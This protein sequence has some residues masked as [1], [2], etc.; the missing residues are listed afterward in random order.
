MF[1]PSFMTTSSQDINWIDRVENLFLRFGIK[2]IT[3]D[4]VAADLGISKKTLYQMVE[5]KDDLVIKVLE[6]HI[7]REKSKCLNLASKAPNA[8]EEIFI[9]LDSNSQEMAQMKTNIVNDLQK[10]H[11]AGW[12]MIQKFHFDFVFKVIRENLLRGRKEG[13]YREDFD[14]D[15]LAKLHLAAAFNLFDPDL[16]PDGANSKVVLLNEYM[17]HY[18]HGIVSPKGL[19]YLLKK[20]LS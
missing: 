13:L 12:E 16:F 18:L 8:L 3:M 15:I 7:S 20:K 17:M 5:S 2:S 19:T 14:I 6:Q 10:Y 9:I 1:T 4:D 11:R